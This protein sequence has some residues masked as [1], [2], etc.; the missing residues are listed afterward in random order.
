M[1]NADNLGSPTFTAVKINTT[2]GLNRIE[3]VY[4]Y[5]AGVE[6]RCSPVQRRA[7]QQ[8]AESSSAPSVFAL[9]AR[10]AFNGRFALSLR[11]YTRELRDART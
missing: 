2:G 10:P 9:V 11:T 1:I 5:A 8:H 7:I 6:A 3:N 4:I